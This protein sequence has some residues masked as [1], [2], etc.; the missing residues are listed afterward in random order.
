MV[1]T[2]FYLDDR[3]CESPFPLKLRLA[4]NR[5]SVY[6]VTNF[7]LEPGQWNGVQMVKHPQSEG[8]ELQ[9]KY[10]DVS[11]LMSIRKNFC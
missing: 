2:K 1:T 7:K 3:K 6:L 10:H 11:K 9:T 5:Q 8:E 4:T